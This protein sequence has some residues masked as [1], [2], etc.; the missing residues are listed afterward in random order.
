MTV[1]RED[2]RVTGVFVKRQL[3]RG[4]LC[5]CVLNPTV[6]SRWIMCILLFRVELVS[7]SAVGFKLMNSRIISL[8]NGYECLTNQFFYI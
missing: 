1:T 3:Q 4:P 5:N 7:I 8:S 2:A 6:I